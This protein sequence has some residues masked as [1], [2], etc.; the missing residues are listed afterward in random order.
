MFDFVVLLH[1]EGVLGL[2]KEI[3]DGILCEYHIDGIQY[4]NTFELD[5]Y[6][7]IIDL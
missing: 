3:A 2:A 4:E 1:E 5:E 6:S 7:V